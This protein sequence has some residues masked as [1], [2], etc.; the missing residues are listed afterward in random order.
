VPQCGDI[1]LT[2]VMT[3]L[4]RI[5]P[6]YSGAPSERHMY[7]KNFSSPAPMTTTTSLPSFASFQEQAKCSEDPDVEGPEIAPM[8]SRLSCYQCTKLKPM[9]R[10]VAIAVTEFDEAIQ[11]YCNRAVTRVRIGL[12]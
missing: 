1:S 9:V 2:A 12:V 3:E 8:S 7:A 6:T 4:P 5:A 10:D 11:T